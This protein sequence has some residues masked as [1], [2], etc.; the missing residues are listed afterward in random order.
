MERIIN[1]FS[2]HFDDPYLNPIAELTF[3]DFTTGLPDLPKE[4]LEDAL[5]HWTSHSGEKLLQTKT[6]ETVNGD[7]RVWFL[8]GLTRPH[9]DLSIAGRNRIGPSVSR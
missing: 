9:F 6:I 4:E 8:H 3:E 5:A 7:K 2:S 1:L